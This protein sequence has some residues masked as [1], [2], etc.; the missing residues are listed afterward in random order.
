VYCSIVCGIT[1][2]GMIVYGITLYSYYSVLYDIGLYS[3]VL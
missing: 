2:Y 3:S 1:L